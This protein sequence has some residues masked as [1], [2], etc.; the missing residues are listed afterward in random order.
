MNLN[1]RIVDVT[2]KDLLR[3]GEINRKKLAEF[4]ANGGTKECAY[5]K[6]TRVF[7]DKNWNLCQK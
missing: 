7:V 6:F 3:V 1:V 2:E 4:K 5:S